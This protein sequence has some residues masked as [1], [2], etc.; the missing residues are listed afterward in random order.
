MKKSIS[1]RKLRAPRK[2][3]TAAAGPSCFT[4]AC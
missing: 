4:G 3:K 2:S 1:V